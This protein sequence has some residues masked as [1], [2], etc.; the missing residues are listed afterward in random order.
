MG[1][2]IKEKQCSCN[3][4]NQGVGR[5]IVAVLAEDGDNVHGISVPETNSRGDQGKRHSRLC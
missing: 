2:G 4:G 3:R 1:P 5:A